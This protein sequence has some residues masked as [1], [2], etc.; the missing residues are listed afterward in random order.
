VAKRKPKPETAEQRA[1][2]FI[3]RVLDAAQA[4]GENAYECDHE[5][6]DLQ[7]VVWSLWKLL[8]PDQKKIAENDEELNN[9]IVQWL[10][11]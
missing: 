11:S 9:L 8:T 6:G 4:H 5:V 3:E 7:G 10:D 2:R 1:D